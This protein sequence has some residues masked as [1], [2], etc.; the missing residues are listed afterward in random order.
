M[1]LK[2]TR[3]GNIDGGDSS[4]HNESA[5][6]SNTICSSLVCPMKGTMAN[7]RLPQRACRQLC[8]PLSCSQEWAGEKKLAA[9]TVWKKSR[10]RQNKDTG[11]KTKKDSCFHERM[12]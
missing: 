3:G 7:G 8:P 1:T 9:N 11:L 12:D 10:D 4:R 5:A 6:Q 2:S